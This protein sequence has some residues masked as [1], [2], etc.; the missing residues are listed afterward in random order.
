MKEEVL[1]GHG[2]DSSP[3]S[4]EFLV[5]KNVAN[6]VLTNETD[7]KIPI[8]NTVNAS[9]C[10][11]RTQLAP[12]V[13]CLGAVSGAVIYV[14]HSR[15]TFQACEVLTG[16]Q[17]NQFFGFFSLCHVCEY[18][19]FY[20]FIFQSRSIFLFFLNGKASKLSNVGIDLEQMS[21]CAF[22]CV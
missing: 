19:Q 2:L 18:S 21:L 6:S 5:V 9:L 11:I 17:K 4:M 13:C 22:M 14:V 7:I 8:I 12:N 16:K 15:V 10:A 20:I 3:L 1:F